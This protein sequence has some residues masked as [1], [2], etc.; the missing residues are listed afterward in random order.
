MSFASFA[1]RR[2]GFVQCTERCSYSVSGGARFRSTTSTKPRHQTHLSTLDYPHSFQKISRTDNP[3][4]IL[5]TATQGQGQH[6]SLRTAHANFRADGVPAEWCLPRL[7]THQDIMMDSSKLVSLTSLLSTSAEQHLALLARAAQRYQTETRSPLSERSRWRHAKVPSRVYPRSGGT[8]KRPKKR[9]R[10]HTLTTST[11]AVLSPHTNP[12]QP[13]NHF[14]NRL[15]TDT[16]HP[17]STRSR[18]VFEGNYRGGM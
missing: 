13:P 11:T 15:P 8:L 4:S 14:P 5:S 16:R 18:P 17:T 2:A 7:R 10:R 1:H 12:H 6:V 9:H 3:E